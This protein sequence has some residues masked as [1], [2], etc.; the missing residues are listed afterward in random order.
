MFCDKFILFCLSACVSLWS[1]NEN[2]DG[3]CLIKTKASY[4]VWNTDAN[5]LTDYT[6]PTR[7][8]IPLRIPFIH[9]EGIYGIR[10]EVTASAVG[11]RNKG[12]LCIDDI[13]LSTTSG[14]L[15]NLYYILNYCKTN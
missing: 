3:T 11:D 14:T 15:N 1:D 10:F 12:R 9:N 6:L 5:L 4:G 13:V 7:T 2:I 8:S